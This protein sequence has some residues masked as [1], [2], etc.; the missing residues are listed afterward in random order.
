[1]PPARVCCY[2]SQM[3]SRRATFIY[4]AM[5]APGDAAPIA[6]TAYMPLL[7]FDA[8]YLCAAMPRHALRHEIRALRL[9][10]SYAILLHVFSCALR[11]C[12]FCRAAAVMPMFSRYADAD[13]TAPP[14]P[15]ALLS[16]RYGLP[17]C[18]CMPMHDAATRCCFAAYKCHVDAQRVTMQPYAAGARRVPALRCC[19]LMFSYDVLIRLMPPRCRLIR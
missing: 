1:M 5:L 11:R 9:R 13:A 12:F 14:M 2:A 10:A 7:P 18:C 15:P 17:S 8:D 16:E 3:A 4:A 6:T 19:C